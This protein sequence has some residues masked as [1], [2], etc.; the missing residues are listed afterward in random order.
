MLMDFYKGLYG[1]VNTDFNSQKDRGGNGNV[2]TYIPPSSPATLNLIGPILWED[3]Y[4]Y[5]TRLGH[6]TLLSTHTERVMC[7]SL[8]GCLHVLTGLS[9]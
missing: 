7:M 2:K 9:T 8:Q 3:M 5:Y 1:C 6:D 4:V